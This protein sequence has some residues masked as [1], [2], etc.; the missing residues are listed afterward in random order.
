MLFLQQ[1]HFYRKKNHSL[2]LEFQNVNDSLMF[3]MLFLIGTFQI[4]LL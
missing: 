2:H 1:Q 3:L 4:L